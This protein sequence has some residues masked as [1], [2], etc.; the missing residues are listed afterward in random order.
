MMLKD[1]KAKRVDSSISKR[2]RKNL[3]RV[4]RQELVKRSSV[5]KIVAA[6]LITVPVSGLLAAILYFTIRGM[7]LP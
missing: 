6:W 1:L 3:K 5:L 2:E 7:M 4:Y